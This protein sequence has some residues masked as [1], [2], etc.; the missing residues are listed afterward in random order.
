MKTYKKN[1]NVFFILLV[2]L[3]L[4]I[5]LYTLIVDEKDVSKLENRTLT[6]IPHFTYQS[7]VDGTYQDTL[8]KAMSDQFVGSEWIKTNYNVLQLPTTLGI[9]NKICQNNYF[10]LSADQYIYNCG[11]YLVE[12]PIEATPEIMNLMLENIKYYSK[13]NEE[14][15]TYY[16]FVTTSNVYD[17]KT[18]NF[19]IDIPQIIKNNM[20]GKYTFDY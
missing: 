13:L 11:D 18:N 19:S 3:I 9:K 14:I 1:I 4:I 5:G 7:F 16:Y 2:V 10:N 17:F 8:E 15:D 12:K 6:K 20:T